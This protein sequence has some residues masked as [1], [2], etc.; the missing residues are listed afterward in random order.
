MSKYF[1]L[2]FSIFRF[3]YAKYIVRAT[4]S[5]HFIQ[6]HSLLSSLA[7]YKR[8]RLTLGRN[9]QLSAFS[10]LFVAPDA[11]LSIGEGTY[12]NKRCIISVQKKISIGKNCLFGPDVKVYDNNHVFEKGHGVIQGKH[13]IKPVKIG[14]NCWIASNVVILPGTHIGNNCVVAANTVVKGEIPDNSIVSMTGKMIVKE[15]S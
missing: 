10:E 8:S 12:L 9:V 14:D 11:Q 7:L 2:L 6:V 5:C 4:L 3:I 1:Q 15:I 13:K